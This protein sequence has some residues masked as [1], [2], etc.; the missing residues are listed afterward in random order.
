MSERGNVWPREPARE[1]EFDPWVALKPY[2]TGEDDVRSLSDIETILAADPDADPLPLIERVI[3][4]HEARRRRR[5]SRATGP[6]AGLEILAKL[7]ESVR[8]GDDFPRAISQLSAEN[9]AFRRLWKSTRMACPM[10]GEHGGYLVVRRRR[11]ASGSAYRFAGCSNYAPD[12]GCRF[13]E[14]SRRYA[15][16]KALAVLALF[17]ADAER[18]QAR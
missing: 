17:V 5:R 1:G 11:Y 13:T 9:V 2:A 3:A 8:C 15:T 6:L 4:F 16:R 18:A 12:G 7:M 14:T 10:C